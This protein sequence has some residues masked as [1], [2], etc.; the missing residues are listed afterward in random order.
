MNDFF[1]ALGWVA[2]GF[3]IG[4]FWNPVWAIAKKIWQEAKVAKHEWR[5]PR[6]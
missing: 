6:K 5:N 1:E 3:V 2:W 4:Y